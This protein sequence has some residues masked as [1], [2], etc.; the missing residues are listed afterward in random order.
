MVEDGSRGA[1]AVS[2]V[3][4]LHGLQTAVVLERLELL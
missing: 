4:E 3:W 1:S 2:G